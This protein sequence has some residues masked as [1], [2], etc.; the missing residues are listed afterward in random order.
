MAHLQ[1]PLKKKSIFDQGK[2]KDDIF[3]KIAVHDT[4]V[5]AL[6]VWN[7]CINIWK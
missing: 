3:T 7:S 1:V 6:K 4:A 2:N 5:S